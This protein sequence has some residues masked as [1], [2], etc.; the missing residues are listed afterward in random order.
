MEVL[1]TVRKRMNLTKLILL[2]MPVFLRV[3]MRNGSRAAADRQE[4]RIN[5]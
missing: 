3:Y 5:K 4:K 2:K 1:H